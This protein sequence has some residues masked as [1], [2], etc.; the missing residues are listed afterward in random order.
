MST[1][2]TTLSQVDRDCTVTVYYRYEDGAQPLISTRIPG[3]RKSTNASPYLKEH[4]KGPLLL[5]A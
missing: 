4:I 2:G 3:K 5:N 1:K